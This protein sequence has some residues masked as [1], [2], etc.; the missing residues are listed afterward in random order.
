MTSIDRRTAVKWV[1]AASAAA[2]LPEFAFAA[3]S[4]AA[5]SGYGKDPDL[6]RKYAAGEL[7]PLTLTEP[8]RR[9]TRVLCDLIIPAD[10]HS[11]A[12]SAVATH[13]FIDEW[14]SAPYPDCRRDREVVVSGLAW[15]DGESQRRHD[16]NFADAGA[17]QTSAIC[18]DICDASDAAPQFAQAALFFR[19]FRELAALG[20]YTTPIGMKDL[21]YVG[22]EPLVAFNG[23][24]PEVL[25]RL[26]LTA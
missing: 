13:E 3:T 11:P 6:L 25:K 7:W 23:P 12:A 22:N 8:Q 5:V 18:D 14:I 1:L 24:P 10:E 2:Q 15:L 20:Y 17:D 26:G 21:R 19:R 4:G 16:K 9:T